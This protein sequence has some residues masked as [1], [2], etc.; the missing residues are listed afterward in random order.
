MSCIIL[1]R[2]DVSEELTALIFTSAL[3]VKAE[4]YIWSRP[5]WKCVSTDLQFVRQIYNPCKLLRCEN[6]GQVIMS[7]ISIVSAEEF[8]SK[9]VVRP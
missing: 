8:N 1:G 3:K 2:F 6:F 9:L 5:K 4:V 7:C